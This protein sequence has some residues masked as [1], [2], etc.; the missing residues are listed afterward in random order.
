MIDEAGT[1]QCMI[2]I[3]PVD[4]PRGTSTKQFT[5]Q[6]HETL[7]DGQANSIDMD[8][9]SDMQQVV[10]QIFVGMDMLQTSMAKVSASINNIGL[11]NMA[12]L[13][14]NISSRAPADTALSNKIWTDERAKLIDTLDTGVSTVRQG[15]LA[16]METALPGTN[17][18][19]INIKGTGVI[20]SF[21]LSE[22][23]TGIAFN[24]D[25]TASSNFNIPLFSD[26]RNMVI[27]IRFKESCVVTVMGTMGHAFSAAVFGGIEF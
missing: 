11:G 14:D 24:V 27:D 13:D 25:G 6:V 20:A 4:E 5:I 10:L 26:K 23:A 7:F 18:L 1:L 22:H 16:R 2:H 15:L 9:P 8:T 17:S 3:M 21:A 12:K 19:A